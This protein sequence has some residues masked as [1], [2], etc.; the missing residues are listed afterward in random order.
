MITKPKLTVGI[1]THEDPNVVL[2]LQSLLMQPIDGIEFL[3]VDNKPD[4]PTAGELHKY[5]REA[6]VRCVKMPESQGTS[7]PRQRLFD[8]ATGEAVLVMDSHVMLRP[9]TL[10]K[11]IAFYDANPGCRDLLTGPLLSSKRQVM[12]THYN[13]GWRS[14]MWGMWGQAWKAPDGQIVSAVNVGGRATIVEM[15]I[16]TPIEVDACKYGDHGKLLAERGYAMLGLQDSDDFVIPGMGLGLFTCRR[17][18][19]VNFHPDFRGFGGAEQYIHDKF[20]MRGNCTRS[21]GFLP[22]WHLFAK[23][24]KKTYSPRLEDKLANTIIGRKDLG[25]PLDDVRQHFVEERKRLKP[26]IWD[27]TVANPLGK[28]DSRPSATIEDLYKRVIEARGGFQKHM[29]L[30]RELASQ[31]EHVTEITATKGSTVAILAGMGGE[32]T[33]TTVPEFVEGRPLPSGFVSWNTDKSDVVENAIKLAPWARIERRPFEGVASETDML[34]LSGE[35]PA[36][37]FARELQWF[38]PAVRRWLVLHDIMRH[39]S[40]LP[41]VKNLLNEG[42]FV[43][44]TSGDQNGLAIFGKQERDRPASIVHAWHPGFGPGTEL[45]TLLKSLGIEQSPTCD[46]NGKALQMDLWGVDGCRANFDQIVQWM[47]D[48]QGR[49]GWKDKLLA[50]A[51]AVKTGLAFKLNPMDPFPALVEEAIRRAEVKQQAAA[52]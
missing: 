26:A 45:K 17:D 36:E 34:L 48:G 25:Q 46:C 51:M 50:A 37:S 16:C 30:V 35:R 13:P 29:P 38:S 39:K 19:W 4:A 41:I 23:L 3:V 6:G 14:E 7:G 27:A 24:V 9:G 15:P 20:K 10:Q 8:E 47:R 11:L 43:I 44:A 28:L 52:A 5:F 21:L 1:A 18:A 12:A 22:W 31:C 42:W 49:W 32:G 2:M 40:L 33:S